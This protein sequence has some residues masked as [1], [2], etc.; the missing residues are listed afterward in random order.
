ML[1]IVIKLSLLF[2]NIVRGGGDAIRYCPQNTLSAYFRTTEVHL[3]DPGESRAFVPN[4]RFCI[5][6]FSFEDLRLGFT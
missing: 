3:S 4:C 6:H 5:L 2:Y 1:F